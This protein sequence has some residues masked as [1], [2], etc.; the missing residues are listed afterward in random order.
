MNTAAAATNVGY[1]QRQTLKATTDRSDQ[2]RTFDRAV[3]QLMLERQQAGRFRAH[4][5]CVHR[6]QN[7]RLGR[8]GPDRPVLRVKVPEDRPGKGKIQERKSRRDGR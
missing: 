8:A 2:E 1:G 7:G 3:A 5:L 4:D 6:S